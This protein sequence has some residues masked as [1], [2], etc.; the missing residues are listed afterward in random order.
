MH[1]DHIKAKIPLD[2]CVRG[3]LYKIH[4]R[5]LRFGVFNGKDAF[6]GIRT[7]FGSRFLDEENHWDA[8]SFATVSGHIDMC[9]S[10]ES[11]LNAYEQGDK[12]PLFKFLEET[13]Q[14]TPWDIK[15]F[16]DGSSQ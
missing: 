15:E 11:A 7:K 14:S 1:A 10:V 16:T 13:E 3:R 9:V 4:C 5:N 8:E 12:E 2:Q 6:I